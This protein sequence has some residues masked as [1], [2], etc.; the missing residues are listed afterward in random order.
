MS[1][2][3]TCH[4]LTNFWRDDKIIWRDG[5]RILVGNCQW[6]T[7]RSLSTHVKSILLIMTIFL[8]LLR[9]LTP[10]P[11]KARAKGEIWSSK[12]SEIEYC[13]RVD[14]DL[15][16]IDL[17]I[18]ISLLLSVTIIFPSLYPFRGYLW[19]VGG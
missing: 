19:V 6:N 12:F 14:I 9:N 4:Y 2:G 11:R 13:L 17:V 3:Q 7:G 18:L 8:T 15:A 16:I 5:I 1:A 10:L